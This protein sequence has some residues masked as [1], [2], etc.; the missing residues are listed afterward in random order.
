M[1]KEIEEKEDSDFEINIDTD[2]KTVSE[3]GYK[4][5]DRTVTYALVRN[6]NCQNEHD[7]RNWYELKKPHFIRC[8]IVF[9]EVLGCCDMKIRSGAGAAQKPLVPLR[10]SWAL[11]A[12]STF[13]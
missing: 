6:L 13:L 10:P 5:T 1:H 12:G 4:P 8:C 9:A 2:L 11:W 7:E 3:A